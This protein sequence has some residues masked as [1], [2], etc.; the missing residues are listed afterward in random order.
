MILGADLSLTGSGIVVL[1][2]DLVVHQDLIKSKTTKYP[3]DEIKRLQGIVNQI[4]IEVGGE[5]IKLA[6]IENLAFMA[7]NTTAL[8]QLSALNY[9]LRAK[10]IDFNIPFVLVAPTTLKKFAIGKGNAGK[11]EMMLSVYKRWEI[12]L[13]NDNLA[14]SY[15]LARIGNALLGID[16]E[17]TKA[18]QEVLK[19]LKPQLQYFKNLQN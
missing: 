19:L 17:L 6:I 15:A 5:L 7:R 4:P 3:V 16:T 9:F 8:V 12:T 14:D 1:K 13:V 10:L 18:Q 2:D 11:N